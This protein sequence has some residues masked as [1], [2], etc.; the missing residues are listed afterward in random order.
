MLRAVL[1]HELIHVVDD[2]RFAWSAGLLRCENN[3]QLQAFSAIL[4]GHAQLLATRVCEAAGWRAD[5]DTYTGLIGYSRP[6]GEGAGA[7]LLA[8]AHTVAISFAYHSGLTFWQH[9]LIH[10]GEG[11]EERIFKSP[12]NGVALISH[13]EWYLN[14]ELRPERLYDL[15]RGLDILEDFI[16]SKLWKATR[17]EITTAQIQVSL[18]VLGEAERKR[19]LES[20]VAM[21]AIVLQPIAAPMSAILQGVL[22]EQSDSVEAAFWLSMQERVMRIRDEK[23]KEGATKIISATYEEIVLDGAT[24]LFVD[25]IVRFQGA[26]VHVQVA[27]LALGPLVVEFMA[28]NHEV[29][30]KTL[31]ET[32]VAMLKAVSQAREAKRD[33]K[34]EGDGD[35]D[36]DSGDGC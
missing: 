32:A 16:S 28:S 21:K 15:D 6:L 18:E 36:A 1:V 14:P 9:M 34:P 17:V 2:Q 4:E 24:G 25:K 3:D 13:P 5:L 30:R 23:L 11:I 35:E 22:Y 10:G 8:R 7:E 29:E 12:P 33:D 20:M 27:T 31:I 19:S 26:D